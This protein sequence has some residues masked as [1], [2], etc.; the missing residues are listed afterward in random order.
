MISADNLELLRQYGR[1]YII[2]TPKSSLKKVE[3]HFL[4][5]DWSVVRDGIFVKLC[6][7]PDNPDE[8]FILC[9]SR[10]RTSKEQAMHDRFIRRIDEGLEKLH[11]T[12]EQ[13]K[14]KDIT[15]TI[16]R[17]VGRLLAKNSRGAIFYTIKTHYDAT[18]QKTVLQVEKND[19]AAHWA[20]QTEGHYLLRTN[21]TDWEPQRLWEAYI[22]LTDAEEAFRIHKSD[23]HLRPIWHQTDDRIKA[24][25]FVCFLSFVLWKSFG[26]MCKNAG[27]GDE[28]RR[29]YNEIKR[30]CMVDVVLTTTEKKELKIRT[31]PRPEKPLQILLHRLGLALPERL[32][33]TLL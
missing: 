28:P 12:C 25:I 4:D 31:V 13:A 16:E 10:E 26:L 32:T 8:K 1:R 3:Q 30:I 14:G 21:I 9:K 29:V 24:H 6:P 27:L 5:S 7:V 22:N 19:T 33:K 11:R 15:G 17:R 23:L 18:H 20:R 2:G